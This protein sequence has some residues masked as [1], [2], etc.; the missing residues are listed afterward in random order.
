M[1]SVDDKDMVSPV[2]PFRFFLGNT[3]LTIFDAFHFKAV[4]IF[5]EVF[6][7]PSDLQE[8]GIEHWFCVAFPVMFEKIMLES[9]PTVQFMELTEIYFNT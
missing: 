2:G 5:V 3:A 7:D 8:V 6:V 9:P 1:V 4:V